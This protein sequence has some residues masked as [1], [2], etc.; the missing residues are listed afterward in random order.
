MHYQ[1]DW[2]SHRTIKIESDE[3][4]KSIALVNEIPL[5]RR[6]VRRSL[7]LN[8]TYL[9]FQPVPLM[10]KSP[11]TQRETHFR[12]MVPLQKMKKAGGKKHTTSCG[13]HH[14]VRPTMKQVL[15][16]K[17]AKEKEAITNYQAQ[18][19]INHLQQTLNWLQREKQGTVQGTKL[20]LENNG[21]PWDWSNLSPL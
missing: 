1:K 9:P 3:G 17:I 2:Q 7:E 5:K 10:R 6:N 13:T 16:E 19:E 20:D 11:Y 14:K 4:V 15:E 12:L 21:N 18:L 8:L